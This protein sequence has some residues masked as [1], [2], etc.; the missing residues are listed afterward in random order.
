MHARRAG[1]TGFTLTELL[2]SMAIIALVVGLAIPTVNRIGGFLGNKSDQAARELFGTLRGARVHAINYR[3]DTAV[4]YVL[5][6]RADTAW[7]RPAYVIDAYGVARKAN[8]AEIAAIRAAN[9]GISETEAKSAYIVVS[10]YDRR[11][12]QFPKDSCILGH[13]E[14]PDSVPATYVPEYPP[15][16]PVLFAADLPAKGMKKILVFDSDYNQIMPRFELDAGNDGYFPAH[17]FKSSGVMEPLDSPVARYIVNVGPAPDA[18]EDERFTVAPGQD[19]AYPEGLLVAPV[20]IELY[21]TTGRVRIT[22]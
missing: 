11:I 2:V 22:S 17:V 4:F 19:P 18:S 8:A 14:D 3:V 12:Q 7:Q 5:S 13:I 9:P 21:R 1:H 20:R 16:T 15:T 6:E 10:E